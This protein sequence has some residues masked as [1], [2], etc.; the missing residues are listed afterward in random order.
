MATDKRVIRH[1]EN[2]KVERA[3]ADAMDPS[4]SNKDLMDD[5]NDTSALKSKWNYP[6]Y[7]SLIENVDFWD[8]LE[9]KLSDY[10][11]FGMVRSYLQSIND[12]DAKIRIVRDFMFFNP[13][14]ISKDFLRWLSA[15][16]RDIDASTAWEWYFIIFSMNSSGQELIDLVLEEKTTQNV[17]VTPLVLRASSLVGASESPEDAIRLLESGLAN[18]PKSLQAVRLVTGEIKL[19]SRRSEDYNFPWF[20]TAYDLWVNAL[21]NWE[22]TQSDSEMA[23]SNIADMIHVIIEGAEIPDGFSAVER[24]AVFLGIVRDIAAAA[25]E[26]FDDHPL[27]GVV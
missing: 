4:R 15:Q 13:S 27:M 17:L 25:G 11:D 26:P 5:L 12:K 16:Q 19:G 14:I 24:Y 18:H 1:G 21:D 22:D 6:V 7:P 3:I 9:S 8:R 2:E 20:D 10:Y 23:S